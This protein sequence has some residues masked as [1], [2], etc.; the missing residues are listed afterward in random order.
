L[1]TLFFIAASVAVQAAPSATLPLF[2]PAD[3]AVLTERA[4]KDCGYAT[5]QETARLAIS[6]RKKIVP[7][8]VRATVNKGPSLVP[9]MIEPGATI[10]SIGEFQGLLTIT[11]QLASDH[12][13]AIAAEEASVT[14]DETLANRTCQDLWLG[15]M[16]D[17]GMDGDQQSGTM[18]VYYLKDMK[19]ANVRISAIG[20]CFE[21]KRSN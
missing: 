10:L 17:A 4:L 20:Q 16:L 12:P 6:D 15:G 9:R 3:H 19:G 1:L 5:P 8:F 11:V 2:T 13:R 18:I 21:K 14:F 7:C